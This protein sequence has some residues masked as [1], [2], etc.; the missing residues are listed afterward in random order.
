MI[1][2][3]PQAIE[4]IRTFLE[5]NGLQKSVRVHL[6]STGC[7]EASLGLMADD[8]HDEDWAEDIQGVVFVIGRDLEKLTGNITIAYIAEPH[9]TGFVLTSENPVSEW[10]GFG[11]C[12]IQT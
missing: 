7:C 8:A 4:T 2:A 1:T 12:D 11:V 6:H 5:K 10:S 9:R 3:T